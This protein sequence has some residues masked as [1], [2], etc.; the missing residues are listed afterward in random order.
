MSGQA[1]L[2]TFPDIF[3]VWMQDLQEELKLLTPYIVV[4]RPR[5]RGTPL[6]LVLSDVDR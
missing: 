2:I 5:E 3:H 4:K 6:C 1:F